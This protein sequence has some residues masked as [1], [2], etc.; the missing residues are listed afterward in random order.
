MKKYILLDFLNTAFRAQFS[1]HAK[2]LDMRIGLSFHVLLN[3]IKSVWQEQKGDHLVVCL[4]SRSW[5]KD[6]YTP[7]KANRKVKLLEMTP[8]EREENDIF[9]ES[10]NEFATFLQEKTNVTV[11]KCE[12]AEA[13]DLIALWIQTHEQDEHIIVSSDSDYY[14][15]LAS[16][17]K[18]YNGITEE[19]ITLD[20]FFDKKGFPIVDKNG[21]KKIVD[22]K[23]ELF[24]KCVRGDT[25]DNIFSAYP[26]ARVKGSK[27]K[28]G[29]REAFQDRNTGG[30]SW[31]NFM[32][33]RWSDHN[34]QEHIVKDDYER[35]VML[36]D[37]TKQPEEV[38][39]RIST[40]I[41]SYHKEPVKN[42]GIHFARFC[43]KWQL[44]RAADRAT[45]FSQILNARNV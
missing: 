34:G 25:S 36:V 21:N 43:N 33:Q 23:W 41:T 17:V 6:V 18:I 26:G 19:L 30:F 27:N 8:R 16:N 15:L 42:I 1:T 12:G 31:N 7:Y 39:N 3:S 9:L 32:L 40:A 24:E 2:D 37:L 29:L 20:G 14:Q 38:R 22:P 11:L 5:R 13:D 44:Q 28:V 10:V 45:E 4:D 35:N